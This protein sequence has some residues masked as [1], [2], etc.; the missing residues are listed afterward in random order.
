MVDGMFHNKF[1]MIPHFLTDAA[2][3]LLGGI[4]GAVVDTDDAAVLFG[5]QE[6]AFRPAD[7]IGDAVAQKL[8]FDFF[9]AFGIAYLAELYLVIYLDRRIQGLH[10]ITSQK[11][12]IL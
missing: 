2:H 11:M 9:F 5:T 8:P 4:L 6:R 3:N 12:N 7:K 1:D 10:V